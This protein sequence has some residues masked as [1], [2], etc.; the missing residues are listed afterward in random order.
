MRVH[1]QHHVNQW[2]TS[3]VVGFTLLLVL[4]FGPKVFFAIRRM[5]LARKPRLEPH[6]A[7]TIW[8]E[9]TLKLL[10]RR[11]IRKLPT[12]TP[13]EFLKTIPQ[14]PVRQ[15]VES[16]TFHYE[17]ARFGDSPEDAEKLPELY[18]E[19]ESVGKK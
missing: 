5:Q 17:R 10:Q 1:F 6:S 13:Q 16:F 8:Y 9:R 3:M 15:R 19:L 4:V 2:T 18:R 14:P 7:A 11:G 12:Q